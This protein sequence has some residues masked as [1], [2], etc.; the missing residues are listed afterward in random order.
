MRY[1]R[2]ES[3]FYLQAYIPFVTTSTNISQKQV[4]FRTL[5][6]FLL[7]TT[8][9]NKGEIYNLFLPSLMASIF[10]SDR[11]LQTAAKYDR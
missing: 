11:E 2:G 9:P 3:G 8:V 5:I 1:E 6:F 7:K 10:F 4:V